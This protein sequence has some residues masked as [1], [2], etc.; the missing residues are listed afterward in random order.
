MTWDLVIQS[1]I[2]PLNSC[3]TLVMLLNSLIPVPHLQNRDNNS[4]FLLELEEDFLKNA[5]K[6][7]NV[8]D[9]VF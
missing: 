6:M 3:V 9:T 1:S 8:S 7:A 5:H 4:L 2:H